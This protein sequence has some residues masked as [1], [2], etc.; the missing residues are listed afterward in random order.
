MQL[1]FTEGQFRKILFWEALKKW[2]DELRGGQMPFSGKKTS[3]VSK[4]V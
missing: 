1:S 3:H 4:G 2:D